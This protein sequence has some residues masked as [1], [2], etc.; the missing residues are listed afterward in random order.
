VGIA[1]LGKILQYLSAALGIPAAAAGTY[2]A[3]QNYFSSAAAC[4]KLRLSIVSIMEQNVSTE[5]KRALLRRDV[6]DFDAR[7]GGQDPDARSFFQAALKNEV[8]AA[9][10]E[11]SSTVATA[12]T[13]APDTLAGN[14]DDLFGRSSAGQVR[15]WV[16]LVRTAPDGP[17]HPNFEGF[18]LSLTSLPPVGTV[19]RARNAVPVWHQPQHGPNNQSQAQGQVAAGHCVRV[20]ATLPAAGSERTWGEVIPVACP[21][22]PTA[23]N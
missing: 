7:C 5:A 6:D 1:N 21:A 19:L 9:A 4:Q 15:G 16:A 17:N 10:I 2:T 14:V 8:A 12:T 18:A 13:S 20:L 23:A 11:P 22:L 3:Y